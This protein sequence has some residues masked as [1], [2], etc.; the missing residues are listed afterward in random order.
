VPL[1]PEYLTESD[2]EEEDPERDPLF[3]HVWHEGERAPV[4][5]WRLFLVPSRQ[6][7]RL[8]AKISRSDEEVAERFRE[9]TQEW[10]AAT[11]FES[12][13]ERVILNRSYQ[14]IIGLGPQVVPLILADMQRARGHWFW[15]LSVIVGEDQAA[16]QTSIAAATEAWL[17]WGRENGILHD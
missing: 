5:E 16:G 6:P 13:L 8:P 1:H 11:G 10:R 7:L 17:A 12:N 15:A 9:L 14:E 4:R 2:W 3:P